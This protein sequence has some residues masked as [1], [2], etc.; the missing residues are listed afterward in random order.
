MTK[1]TRA[2]E[3]KSSPLRRVVI[4]LLDGAGVGALPDAAAGG[5]VAITKP[6]PLK[7]SR[8][9]GPRSSLADLGASAASWL[10]LPPLENGSSFL[11]P[12]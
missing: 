7:Q 3:Q 8:N 11:R 2:P 9:L 6:P 4:A 1:P 10:N 5:P 12:G